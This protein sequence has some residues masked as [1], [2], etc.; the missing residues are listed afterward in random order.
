M[1]AWFFNRTK[2]EE[3]WRNDKVVTVKKNVVLYFVWKNNV[4]STWNVHAWSSYTDLK[5]IGNVHGKWIHCKL[6]SELEVFM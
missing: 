4:K 3:T 1:I 5:I 6:G 2:I